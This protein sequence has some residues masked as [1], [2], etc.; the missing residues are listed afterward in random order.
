LFNGKDQ[1]NVHRFWRSLKIQEGYRNNQREEGR[2]GREDNVYR[3]IS[4]EKSREKNRD[5]GVN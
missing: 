4:S 1:Y 3:A 2:L 5:L